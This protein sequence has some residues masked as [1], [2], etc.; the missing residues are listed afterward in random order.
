MSAT[1]GNSISIRLFC[2]TGVLLIALSS[3]S[4]N[5]AQSG[6]RKFPAGQE[7]SG[8]LSSYASLAP[9]PNFENTK[10]FVSKDPVKNIHAYVAAI[11][12]PPAVYVATDADQS[13][14]PGRG[15]EALREYFRNA[16]ANA[17]S[18]AFPI[19]QSRGP[20][21]LRLRSAIVGVD[22]GRPQSVGSGDRSALE[23]TVNI[24]K[25]GVEIEFVDSETG[26]QIAAAVDRQNLGK[27]AEVGSVN[28][29]REAK[30]RA[31]TEAFD[32][33]A[34]RLREFVNAAGELSPQ[35]VRRVEETNFLYAS[36]GTPIQ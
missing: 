13:A 4:R 12:D 27:G 20:L 29:S 10:S 17:V 11:I 3:C 1:S 14:L 18:D 35:D 22:V 36:P 21:V 19:V 16:I 5:T 24:G 25:V 7:F 2:V 28:F 30:F 31:A 6:V 9:N 15:V 33:W 23:R 8:F 34:F 26:E 32:G